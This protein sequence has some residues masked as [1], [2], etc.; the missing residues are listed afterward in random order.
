LRIVKYRLSTKFSLNSLYKI[1]ANLPSGNFFIDNKEFL[2]EELP[3]PTK[4]KAFGFHIYS[5]HFSQLDV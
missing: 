2:K 1:E 3:Q 5:Q 4:M